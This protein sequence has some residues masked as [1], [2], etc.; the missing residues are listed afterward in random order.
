MSDHV[1]F[2]KQTGAVL[3]EL[4]KAH[5]LLQK[6][7]DADDVKG[8]REILQNL[9]KAHELSSQMPKVATRLPSKSRKRKSPVKRKGPKA[10]GVKRGVVVQN[11]AGQYAM[12]Q[13]K[14]GARKNKC[15]RLTTWSSDKSGGRLLK[16]DT[17]KLLNTRIKDPKRAALTTK[18]KKTKM[19]ACEIAPPRQRHYVRG[20]KVLKVL[21]DD[22]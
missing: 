12:I 8:H 18:S 11:N 17:P 2:V 5:D 21:L 15:R 6:G 16:K 3:Q 19:R 9:Q 20:G 13:R 1:A 22:N 10:A 14:S 4:R 7:L